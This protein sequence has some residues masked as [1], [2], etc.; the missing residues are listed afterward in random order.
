MCIE[1]DAQ[2]VQETQ[3]PLSPL[4]MRKIAVSF[5]SFAICLKRMIKKSHRGL[6]K[7]LPTV[8]VGVAGHVEEEEVAGVAEEVVVVPV[9]VEG[10]TVK[11]I[12]ARIGEAADMEARAALMEEEVGTVEDT[13]RAGDTRKAMATSAEE[14]GE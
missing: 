6:F 10:I 2:V 4:S 8:V 14:R 13:R 11:T 5:V 3:V 1:L 7:W 12:E 9:S